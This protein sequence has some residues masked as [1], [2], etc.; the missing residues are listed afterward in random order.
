[1]LLATKKIRKIISMKVLTKVAQI[2]VAAVS[3]MNT[4]PFI[5]GFDNS[6]T[7]S[8][9]DLRLGN[10]YKCLQLFRKDEVDIALVP[11]A[12]LTEIEN[13]KII[14]PFCIGA[15]GKVGSVFLLSN[16]DIS[17]IET[18]YC[19]LHSVTSNKLIEL[20]CLKHWNISP[21]IRFPEIYP[22]VINKNEAVV[23]IGDKSFKMS[24]QYAFVYDLA[25][26]W[27]KMTGKAF[28][29][30]VWLTK[31]NLHPEII[32]GFNE[33]LNFGVTNIND[34]IAYC[35]PQLLPIEETKDYLTNKIIYRMDEELTEGMLEFLSLIKSHT[36]I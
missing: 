28:V 8:L 34:S 23:A 35:K 30:A 1:V 27:K 12:A 10:P 17:S 33:A 20:L 25:E 14:K 16:N 24:K 15:N 7:S 9:I 36:A 22:P 11:V 26:E 32:T 31:K 13:P 18:I 29:F 19:D 5:Y 21:I 3:Y 4:I 6:V 2:K